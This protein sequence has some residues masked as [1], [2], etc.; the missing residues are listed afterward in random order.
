MKEFDNSFLTKRIKLIAGTDEAGRGPLAGPVVAAAVIFHPNTFIEGVND[1]KQLTEE[2]RE[3]LVPLIIKKSL[4]CSVTAISH[5]EIERINI[6]QASLLAMQTSIKRLNIKPNLILVDGNK[7]FNY[8]VPAIPVIKGDAKSFSIAAA[9][10]LAK[11]ARDRIMKRLCPRFP[12]YLWSKNKG[13]ATREHIEAI[14]IYG[15]TRFHRMTFL[16]RILND[17]VYEEFDFEM[18]PPTE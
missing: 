15:P 18:E 10:I 14:K 1:S 3:K 12:Q 9:S 5:R 6:L 7:T 11:V 13:Y 8:K 17:E 4:A 2:E 16:S